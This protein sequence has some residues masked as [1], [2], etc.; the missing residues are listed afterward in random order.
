MCSIL[1]GLICDMVEAALNIFQLRI[2]K[3]EQV[4]DHNIRTRKSEYAY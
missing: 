1:M 4:N 2:S 3:E